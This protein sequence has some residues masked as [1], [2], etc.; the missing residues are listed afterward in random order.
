MI[1]GNVP[2]AFLEIPDPLKY[3]NESGDRQFF[4]NIFK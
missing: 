3:I 2:I 1:K 4:V